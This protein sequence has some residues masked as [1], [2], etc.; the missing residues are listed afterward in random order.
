M[1]VPFEQRGVEGDTA[2]GLIGP[3]LAA[4]LDR[5]PCTAGRPRTVEDLPGGLT[6]RNLKVCTPDATVVVRIS[7]GATSLLSID[8]DNEHA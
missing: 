2:T 3:E 7:A 6:N 1:N 4:L 5:M 8:R